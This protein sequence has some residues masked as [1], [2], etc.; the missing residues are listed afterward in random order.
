V[1]LASV[2]NGCVIGFL[3]A[4]FASLGSDIKNLTQSLSL[5]FL[6][7]S[8]AFISID[9]ITP[10]VGGNLFALYPAAVWVDTARNLLTGQQLFFPVGA[11]TWLLATLLLWPTAVAFSSATRPILA[12]KIT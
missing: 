9:A 8:G 6:A 12:E 10:R 11:A 2:L 4:P 1:F 5:A 7:A 3:I